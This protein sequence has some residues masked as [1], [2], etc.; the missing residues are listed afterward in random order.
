MRLPILVSW[1][2]LAVAGLLAPAAPVYAHVG[3]A[4]AASPAGAGAPAAVAVPVLESSS[5]CPT[6]TGGCCC[7]ADRSAGYKP[8]RLLATA[9]AAAS[10]SP[11]PSPG[12][13]VRGRR[14]VAVSMAGAPATTRLARAPPHLA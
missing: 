12:L 9:R 2:L 14:V 7:R 6:D 8:S 4:G 5:H 11:V 13:D 3:H 10:P 1:L